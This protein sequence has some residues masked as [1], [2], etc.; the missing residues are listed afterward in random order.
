VDG[1]MPR[2]QPLSIVIRFGDVAISRTELERALGCELSRYE[3]NSARSTH[4]A[5]IDVAEATDYWSAALEKIQ[6]LPSTIGQLISDGSIGSICLDV[7][8]AFPD[9]VMSTSSIVPFALAEAVGRLG[10]DIELSIY[11]TGSK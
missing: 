8:I 11:R 3:P 2:S 10:V 6:A 1:F 7:A 4:Y 9:K 5:Q